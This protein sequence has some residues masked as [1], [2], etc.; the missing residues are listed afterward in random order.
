MLD[1]SKRSL[2]LAT[3]LVLAVAVGNSAVPPAKQVAIFGGTLVDVTNR[4]HS[5]NDITDS[6]VLI[7]GGKIVAAGPASE[8]KVPSD[9]ARIDARGKFLVPGLIDGFGALRN[10]DSRMLTY[11]TELLLFTSEVSC[12]GAEV[13]VK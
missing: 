1:S 10:Q 9:F 7:E 5:S 2:W 13:M 8:I 3:V 6:V 12:L 4:G 11:M